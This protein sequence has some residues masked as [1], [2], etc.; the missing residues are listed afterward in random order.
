MAALNRLLVSTADVLLAP[1][2]FLPPLAGIALVSL[3]TAAAM[4]LVIKRTSNQ[5]RLAQVKRAIEAR[6]FELRLFADDVPAILRTEREMVRHS[7]TYLRLS[8]V[9]ALWLVVPLT[10]LIIHLDSF[11]GYTGLAAGTPSLLTASFGGG[12]QGSAAGDPRSAADTP[13]VTVGLEAPSSIRVD[14]PA[15]WF[16]GAREAVWSITP[17]AAGAHVVRVRVGH[18]VFEKTVE[19]SGAVGR[20]SP[21]RLSGGL[22][23]RLANPSEA[24]LPARHGLTAIAV[25]Y[26]ERV[27]GVLGWDAGWLALYLLLTFAFMLALKRPLGVVL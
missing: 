16:P 20:R 15:V 11:F 3:A 22:L 12:P 4:L 27:I 14:T 8:L 24:P 17:R 25:A 1:L 21:V 2:V 7:L 9:P 13:A 6:I 26:P 18:E 5:R 19:V 10:L 23:D